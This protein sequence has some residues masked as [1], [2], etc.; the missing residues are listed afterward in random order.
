MVQ[1]SAQE[2]DMLMLALTKARKLVEDLEKQQAEIEASPPKISPEKLAEGRAA[3]ANV[4]R[5]RGLVV[6]SLQFC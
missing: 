3:F 1:T 2:R 6:M 4:T 5:S